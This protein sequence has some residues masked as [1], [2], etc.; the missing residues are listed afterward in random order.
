[1]WPQQIPFPRSGFP[2][3]ENGPGAMEQLEPE[4]DNVIDVRDF[5]ERPGK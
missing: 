5:S 4:T 3:P 1:M 2:C